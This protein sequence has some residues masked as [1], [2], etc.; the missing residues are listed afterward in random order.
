MK[1]VILAGGKGTRLMPLT[2]D[3][4]KPMIKILD[5]PCLQYI[6]ELLA[7]HGITD[8]AVTLGYKSEVIMEYFGDGKNLGVNLTYFVEDTPLGTA[9]SVKSTSNFVSEDFIVMSGDA[10][11]DLDI[12]RAAQYHF[13]SDSVFTVVAKYLEKPVGLGLIKTDFN[14]VITE[15]VEKP[16]VPYPALANTG[17]YIV[18]K[19]ILQLIPDGFYDFGKQLLPRL[20]G[21]LHAYPC[22]DY[23]S[24]IGTL[25]SYYTT[26]LDASEGIQAN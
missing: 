7:R 18:N 17:I 1:A 14:N 22:Y 25:Q 21:H 11:T 23:W 16:A 8:I 26:N 3:I 2:R 9:G 20:V 5:K 4:P 19:G 13:A 6:I 24:D 12:T 10:Y 15:F